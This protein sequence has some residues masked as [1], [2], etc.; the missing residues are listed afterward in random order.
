M[1]KKFVLSLFI[2]DSYLRHHC[3]TGVTTHRD[4]SKDPNQSWDPLNKANESSWMNITN[5]SL[6]N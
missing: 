3:E 4:S 1:T 5:Y 6:I 2:E